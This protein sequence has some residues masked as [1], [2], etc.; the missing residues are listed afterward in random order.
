[1]DTILVILGVLGL[2]AIVISAYVFAASAR[3]YVSHNGNGKRGTHAPPSR[4][5]L[6]KRRPTDRRSGKPVV[7]PLTVNSVLVQQDRR[8]QPD[9]RQAA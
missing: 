4:A 5:H 9:R 7:F 8:H 6:A 3:K 1:M 2:G